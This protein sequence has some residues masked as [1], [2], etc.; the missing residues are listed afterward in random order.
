MNSEGRFS[1]FFVGCN[2]EILIRAMVFNLIKKNCIC[3]CVGFNLIWYFLYI[4]AELVFKLLWINFPWDI[5]RVYL[6]VINVIIMGSSLRVDCHPLSCQHVNGL[7]FSSFFPPRMWTR[8]REKTW[9]PT[10]GGT[11]AQMEGMRSPWG[12]PTG[13]ATWTWATLQSW[14]RTTPWSARGSPKFQT[15][16]SGRSNRWVYTIFVSTHTHSGSLFKSLRKTLN[17]FFG[18]LFYHMPILMPSVCP[19]M[20][21]AN[22]L[23]KEEFPDFDDETGI[24]PKVDDEEGKK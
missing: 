1:D 10:G 3:V 16:R 11:L 19:Q 7:M 12:T 15:Q 2:I 13:R 17:P 14:S 4:R 5:W 21:A 20:I 24:L 6:D 9:T 8:R 22:V 18:G 23:S